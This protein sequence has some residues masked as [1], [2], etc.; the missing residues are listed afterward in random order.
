MRDFLFRSRLTQLRQM[1]GHNVIYRIAIVA[2]LYA[3]AVWLFE[4]ERE[5]D[6]ADDYHR[7]VF[8]EPDYFDLHETGL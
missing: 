2:V 1:V 8:I 4:P 3:P 7:A 6:F 5:I